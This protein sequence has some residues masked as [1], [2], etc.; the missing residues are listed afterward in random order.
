M[1]GKY[2]ARITRRNPSAFIFMLDISGSMD[3]KITFHGQS[4][5]KSSAVALCINNIISELV[6]RCKRDEGYRDYFDIAILGYGG[7][8]AVSLLPEGSTHKI[9]RKPSELAHAKT[10]TVRNFK[11][12]KLPDG[13]TVVAAFDTKAWV[14]SR[15][16]GKTP[17][18]S[19][20]VKAHELLSEWLV[21]HKD[22]ECFPPVVINITD[23]EATDADER[24][25]LNMAQKIKEL[26]TSDGNVLLMNV[27]IT[28]D[29]ESNCI[30]LPSSADELPDKPYAKLL[31]EMSSE[32][33]EIFQNQA[34]ADN[35]KCRRKGMCYNA[36]ISDI[37]NMLNIGSVS[38]NLVE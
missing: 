29:S 32:L 28:P 3:D 2:T 38:V 20:F 11:E 7:E 21:L 14:K 10:G 37:V 16:E 35:G 17:M 9:F 30:I 25:L 31:F 34:G 13:R 15:A 8:K 23:G 22:G 26:E 36:S 19:A 33:P 5:T 12:R 4:M 24:D 27:F 1:K 6:A 18:F